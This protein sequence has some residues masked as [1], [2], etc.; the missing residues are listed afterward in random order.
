MRAFVLSVC[1]IPKPHA[2]ESAAAVFDLNVAT[3]RWQARG[4]LAST[5]VMRAGLFMR[6]R[7]LPPFRNHGRIGKPTLNNR[8]SNRSSNQLYIVGATNLA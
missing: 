1:S 7:R 4:L 3:I 5:V 2:D 6:R 8:L